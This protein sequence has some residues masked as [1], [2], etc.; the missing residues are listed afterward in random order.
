L[1]DNVITPMNSYEDSRIE[2]GIAG[3]DPTH[4]FTASCIWDIPFGCSLT[5]WKRAIPDSRQPSGIT[6]AQTGNPIVITG[7]GV[8]AGSQRPNV[9]GQARQLGTKAMWFDTSV[10]SLPA[11]EAFGN[12]R[13]AL[14]R[15]PGIFNTDFSFSKATRIKERTTLQFRAE[16]FN[17]FH[18]TQWATV[19]ETLGSATFGQVT[20]ARDPRITQLGLWL[21]F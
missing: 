12:R 8:E 9:N 11:V 5:P 16:F 3:F 10:F 17:I 18:H 6:S 7:A 19:R 13:R 20:S 21:M 4:V 2:R 1:I 15:G 14:V